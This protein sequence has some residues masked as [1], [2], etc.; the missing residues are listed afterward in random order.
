MTITARLS[1]LSSKR[2]RGFFGSLNRKNLSSL[3]GRFCYKIKSKCKLI[4]LKQEAFFR[5]SITIS[6]QLFSQIVYK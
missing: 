1:W 2:V 3:I 4:V 5:F 6:S